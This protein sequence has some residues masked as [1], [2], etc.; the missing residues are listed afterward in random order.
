VVA[1]PAAP[2]TFLFGRGL[3]EKS[4]PVRDRYA[5]EQAIHGDWLS[6]YF[7]VGILGAFALAAAF[8]LAGKSTRYK[9]NSAAVAGVY[10]FLFVHSFFESALN[11]LSIVLP[12]FIVLIA[13][14]DLARERAAA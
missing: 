9:P 6:A 2:I 3:S 8:I 13:T 10:I 5:P 11:D 12:V 14:S 4:I 1:A 7:E